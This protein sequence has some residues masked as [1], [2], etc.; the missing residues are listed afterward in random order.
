MTHFPHTET[1]W[2]LPSPYLEKFGR[3]GGV[4]DHQR[5]EYTILDIKISLAVQR[6]SREE[7]PGWS[8]ARGAVVQ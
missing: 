2:S 4:K 5:P 6:G 1:A 8:F 3:C 7:F